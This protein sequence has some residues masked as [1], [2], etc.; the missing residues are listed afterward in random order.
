MGNTDFPVSLVGRV[1][2]TFTCS[3]EKEVDLA[4]KDAK[5][6]FKI[7]SQ[8][9]GLERCQVLLE[10]ARMIRVCFH[11]CLLQNQPLASL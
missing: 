5:A 2:A 9:S 4:V 6:A 10:A 11:F 7:W 8:K 3:G 1:I